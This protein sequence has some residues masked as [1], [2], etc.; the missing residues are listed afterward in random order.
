MTKHAAWGIGK[1]SF[2]VHELHSDEFRFETRECDL[3]KAQQAHMVSIT[4]EAE[5]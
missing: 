5:Q 3:L 2:T 4:S 1:P